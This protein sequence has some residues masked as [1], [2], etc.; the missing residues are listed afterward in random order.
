METQIGR[1]PNSKEFDGRIDELSI[2]NVALTASQIQAIFNAGTDG[3][4][5]DVPA[6]D[7]EK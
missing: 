1:N 2:Y 4:C 3:K 6:I 7:I 5:K